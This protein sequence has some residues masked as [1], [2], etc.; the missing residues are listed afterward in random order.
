MFRAAGEQQ[1]DLERGRSGDRDATEIVPLLHAAPRLV[2]APSR[3]LSP[4]DP[5]TAG[6]GAG[7]DDETQI[8]LLE[9]FGRPPS[10]A[11]VLQDFAGAEGAP[12]PPPRRLGGALAPLRCRAAFEC[13]AALAES[14]RLPAA[15][16]ADAAWSAPR[17]AALVLIVSLSL[18]ALWYATPANI[19]WVVQ[20][21]RRNTAWSIALFTLA[22]TAGVIL[23]LPGMLFSVAAGAAFG[24]GAGAAV[25]F[26]ST[27]TGERPRRRRPPPLTGGAA[28]PCH[29]SSNPC[30]SKSLSRW[31]A[32]GAN[33]S[34][35]AL[36]VNIPLT[37]QPA[38]PT[39]RAAARAA[40]RPRH[41]HCLLVGALPAA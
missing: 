1:H 12:Q 23:M 41:D 9:T 2:P 7:L 5:L 24:F 15:G 32:A 29:A 14:P 8:N 21:M 34:P 13:A 3:Q 39:V 35:A 18:V 30:P 40:P 37:P 17:A 36:L 33:P 4:G 20:L 22:F 28:T 31:R 10:G 25:S 11:S 6:A 38:A 26:V 16:D 27:V 19:F